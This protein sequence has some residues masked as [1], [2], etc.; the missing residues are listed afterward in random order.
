MRDN[1]SREC[2]GVSSSY[3]S[4]IDCVLSALIPF[5]IQRSV[6]RWHKLPNRRILDTC[7]PLECWAYALSSF[8]R[9][10]TIRRQQEPG[11]PSTTIFDSVFSQWCP[12]RL[13]LL[14]ALPSPTHLIP[15]HRASSHRLRIVV[16][17]YLFDTA[18]PPL[19]TYLYMADCLHSHF[20]RRAS[21]QL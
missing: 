10:I 15:S 19:P 12:P 2:R 21:L 3:G 18:P 13:V 9:R 17:V 6:S 11:S 8:E 1:C 14:P 4:R 20:P 16:I 5:S 7:L